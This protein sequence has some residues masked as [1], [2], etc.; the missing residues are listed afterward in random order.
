MEMTVVMIQNARSSAA[1][2]EQVRGVPGG[3]QPHLPPLAPQA[4]EERQHDPAVLCPC[5]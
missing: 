1:R 2:P 3:R 4:V 5:S